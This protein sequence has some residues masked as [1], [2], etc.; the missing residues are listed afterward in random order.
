V[1][2]E[3]RAFIVL[4]GLVEDPVTGSLNAA[5]GQWL[6]GT[7]RAPGCYVT[8]QGTAIGRRGRIHVSKA[9]GQVWVGGDTVTGVTGI[10]HR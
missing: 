1:D 5:L 7:Q 4:D 2:F 8:A 6:I 3:V 10:V 9:D